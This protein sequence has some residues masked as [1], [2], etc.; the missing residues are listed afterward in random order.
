MNPYELIILLSLI[1]STVTGI[2]TWMVI[3][4][5]ELTENKKTNKFFPMFLSM[6]LSFL[7]M[8][9][10]LSSLENCRTNTKNEVIQNNNDNNNG[11][12]LWFVWTKALI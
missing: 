1:L 5:K 3:R 6:S 12:L 9:S 2:M 8:F 7:F 4:G 11:L 10:F